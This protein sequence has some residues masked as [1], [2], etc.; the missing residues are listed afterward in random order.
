MTWKERVQFVIMPLVVVILTAVSVNVVGTNLQE[1]SFKRNE[2]F[3]AKLQRL[4]AAQDEARR[5]R[6]EANDAFRVIRS[7]EDDA[8]AQLQHALPDEEAS[9]RNDYHTQL[10]TSAA[11]QTLRRSKIDLDLLL[12][13]IRGMS[14]PIG[15]DSVPAALARTYSDQLTAFTNCVNENRSFQK[16]CADLHDEFTASLQQLVVHV[17]RR[18]E[19]LIA[20]EEGA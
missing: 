5:I 4:T 16:S 3:K 13:D 15:A 7:H 8:R 19:T 14:T 10:T 18:A 9:L 11:F 6:N 2:L 20:A 17:G 12:Q 1:K